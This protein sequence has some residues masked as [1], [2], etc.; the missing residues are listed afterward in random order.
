MALHK[1]IEVDYSTHYEGQRDQIETYKGKAEVVFTPTTVQLRD[2]GLVVV[3]IAATD[4]AEIHA[5]SERDLR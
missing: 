2:R 4:W 3:E 1:K 5:E